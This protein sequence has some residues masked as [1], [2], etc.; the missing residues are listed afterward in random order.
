MLEFV[1]IYGSNKTDA[2]ARDILQTN[3]NLVLQIL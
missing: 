3:P 1:N 2:I